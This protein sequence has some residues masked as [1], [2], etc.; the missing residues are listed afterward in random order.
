[1]QTCHAGG[2]GFAFPSKMVDVD[3][4]PGKCLRSFLRKVVSDSA[5]DGSVFILANK[6]LGI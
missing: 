1:M 2:R 6:F 5:R 4:S 3:D